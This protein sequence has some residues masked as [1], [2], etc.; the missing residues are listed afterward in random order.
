MLHGVRQ[1]NRLVRPDELSG[2]NGRPAPLVAFAAGERLRSGIMS[3]GITEFVKRTAT[4]IALASI[5]FL[6]WY[7]RDF[8]LVLV[9]SVLVATLLRLLSEPFVRWCRLPSSIGLAISGLLLLAVIGGFAFLFGTQMSSELEDVFRRAN[10]ATKSIADVLQHS[11]FGRLALSH[12]GGG[13]FSLTSIISDVLK[14]SAHFLEALIFVVF[15]GVYFAAQPDIYRKGACYLFPRPSRPM[16]EETLDDVGRALR[17]WLI[18]QL[19]QMCLI[20]L[21]STIA[22]W[23]IGLPSPLALG[24]IAGIAEFVPYVGPII[25]AIPAVLVAITK[26]LHPVLWTVIAYI[27]IHQ[28]EGNLIAPIIQRHMVLVPP[29]TLLLSIVAISLVFG[30]AAIVF[31]A[32]MTVIGVVAVK[33]LYVRDGLGQSTSLPGEA[34]R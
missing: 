25:A 15:A 5:A 12:M 26:G 31:A 3:F 9:G 13:S 19:V 16:A 30:S 1:Y 6:A 29:A 17:L 18:G 23:L 22:V 4:A 8:F 11:Q 20:G 21:I 24:A 34:S 14:L 2:R 27:F 10:S 7:I 32:P 33:K 28:L